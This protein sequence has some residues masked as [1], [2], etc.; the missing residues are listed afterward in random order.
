MKKTNLVV[1]TGYPHSG[2]TTVA[3]FLVKHGFVRLELDEVRR[4][5]FG[6]GFPHISNEEEREARLWFHYKKID[7][8]SRGKSVVLDT[9]STT[10][11]DRLENLLLPESLPKKLKVKKY[12]IC[13]SVSRSILE[14]RNLEDKAR[15]RKL[16]RKVFR[17]IDKHWDNPRTYKDWQ[18]NAEILF[19]KNNNLKDL[20]KIKRSLEKDLHLN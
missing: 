20:E 10:N 5:L 7:L 11:T 8:L 12:L 15:D 17:D 16:F 6:K 19:Y 1:L 14:K 18:S 3:K 9:C 13:I 2:K 4:E